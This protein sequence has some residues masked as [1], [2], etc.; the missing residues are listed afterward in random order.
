MIPSDLRAP[1]LELGLDEHERL[2]PGAAI[3]RSGGRAVRT[4]MKETSHTTSSGANG[5]SDTSRAFVRSSTTRVSSRSFGC[6]WPYPTSRA[7]TRAAPFCNRQSVKPPVEAPTSRQSAPW[8]DVQCVQCMRELFSTAG[9]EPRR[10]RPRAR[11]IRPPE[12]RP[13]R[14]HARG[15]RAR[16][17]APGC[18]LGKPALDEQDV[19]PLLHRAGRLAGWRIVEERVTVGGADS[20]HAPASADALIDDDAFGEDEFLPY[21]AELWPS[22]LALAEHVAGGGVAG[23]RV[24]ELGCGLALPS[25]AAALGGA[26]VLATDWAADAVALAGGNAQRTGSRC[27]RRCCAGCPAALAR[28]LR[29]RPRRRRP[30]RGP[31]RAAAAPPARRV[32]ARAARPWSPIPAAATRPPSSRPPSWPGGSWSTLRRRARRGG[33]ARLTRLQAGRGADHEDFVAQSHKVLPSRG[34]YAVRTAR[35]STTPAARR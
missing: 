19:E 22:G 16:A 32:V 21:W 20:H 31:Q 25:L 5:R 3:R 29:P 34:F 33:I 12:R 24:L 2:P 7:I 23:A 14:T 11:R 10:P 27:A 28:A 15:R 8:I 13:C 1:G 6:S 9:D 17:P 18:A 26:D 4:E 35:S 30:L